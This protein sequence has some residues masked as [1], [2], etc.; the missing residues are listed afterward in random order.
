MKTLGYYNGKYD[1]LENM[2][3]PMGFN[4]TQRLAGT[5]SGNSWVLT[6]VPLVTWK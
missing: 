5:F 6:A 1:E 3:V 4:I 2:S